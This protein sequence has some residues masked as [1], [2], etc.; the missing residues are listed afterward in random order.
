MATTSNGSEN[1]GSRGRGYYLEILLA[2]FAGLVLEIS[3]T[4]ISSFKLFYYYTYLVIGLAL[5]GIGTGGVLVAIS[6]RLRRAATERVLSWSLLL[7]AASIGVGYIIVAYT[8]LDDTAIWRY[9]T[10]GSVKNLAL[11]LV[12]CITLAISFVSIGVIIATLFGRRPERVGALYFADLVGAGVACAI[13]V[14]FVSSIGPP[15][16]IFVAGLVMALAALRIELQRR[17]AIILAAAAL[18]AIFAVFVAAPGLLPEQRLVTGKLDVV[19]TKIKDT[20]WSPIF[21][22]DAVDFR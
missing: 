20:R 15:A 9:G 18:V 14:S 4:R 3:Y 7:G 2:S 10:V 22:V 13:V 8:S 12:I 1:V 16:T 6:P 5:L 21:R 11:L 19:N 17:S